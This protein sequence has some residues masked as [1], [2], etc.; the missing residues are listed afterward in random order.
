MAEPESLLLV[1]TKGKGGRLLK[2][3]RGKKTLGDGGKWGSIKKGRGHGGEGGS[4]KGV[5]WTS[6]FMEK[7]I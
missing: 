1:W 2:G 6:F 7:G 5:L 4:K 3:K